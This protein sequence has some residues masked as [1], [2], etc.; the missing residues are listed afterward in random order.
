M[1]KREQFTKLDTR[2]QFILET[3]LPEVER[4]FQ[5][6]KAQCVEDES[7]NFLAFHGSPLFNWHAILRTGLQVRWVR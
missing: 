1:T 2:F 4:E 6:L 3:S 7:K 5:T